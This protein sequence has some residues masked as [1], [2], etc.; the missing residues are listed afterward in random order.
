M[1]FLLL[2]IYYYFKDSSV[3]ILSVLSLSQCYPFSHSVFFTDVYNPKFFNNLRT[4]WGLSS[5]SVNQE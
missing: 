4:S 2:L 5:N 1:K 3:M